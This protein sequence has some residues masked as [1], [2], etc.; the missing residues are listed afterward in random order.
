MTNQI[1]NVFVC[2]SSSGLLDEIYYDAARELGHLLGKQGYNVTYGGGALGMMY[3]NA[4]AAKEAG[5]GV[6]GVLPEKLHNLGVGEGPCDELFIVKDMRARK[7]K[8]DLISDATI[9]LP[10]GYG[11]LEELSELMVQKQLAYN[12]KAIV[13][14]NT[15]GFYDELLM[16]FDK[17]ISHKFATPDSRKLIFIAKT[18]QEAIDYL[19]SYKPCAVDATAKWGRKE[20]TKTSSAN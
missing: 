7:E 5:G 16:F 11:T 17:I 19:K 9:A 12:N 14:L 15:N 18:P 13:I 20:E 3:Q 2:S 4:K 6:I 1:K 10:G 8:L